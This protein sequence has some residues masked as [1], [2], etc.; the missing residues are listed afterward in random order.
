MYDTFSDN[1]NIRPMYANR[2]M[3]KNKNENANI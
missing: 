1:Y 3:L 2:R